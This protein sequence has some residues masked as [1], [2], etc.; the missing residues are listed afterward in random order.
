MALKFRIL[1]PD[2]ATE[3]VDINHFR[4]VAGEDRILRLQIFDDIDDDNYSIADPG[5]INVILPGYPDNIEKV[6][7]IQ[8]DR[9]IVV[10][11]LVDTDTS[12]MISGGLLGKIT[13]NSKIRYV[14]GPFLFKKLGK[15]ED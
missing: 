15:L 6:G 4:F 10:V 7:T 2:N 14:R 11:E 3:A 1:D 12:S 13:E 5:D 9:S 8:S